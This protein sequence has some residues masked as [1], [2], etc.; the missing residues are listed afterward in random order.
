MDGLNVPCISRACECTCTRAYDAR[1]FVVAGYSLDDF[2]GDG[3]EVRKVRCARHPRDNG[4]LSGRAGL[5]YLCCCQTRV[6][7]IRAAIHCLTSDNCFVEFIF[8]NFIS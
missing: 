8:F 3:R 7:D 4:H 6:I 2:T 1:G 5:G